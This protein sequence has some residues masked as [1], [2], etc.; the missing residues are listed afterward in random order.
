VPLQK[1]GRLEHLQSWIW[2]ADHSEFIDAI[3]L[4]ILRAM[5]GIGAAATI[6]ASLGILAQSFPPSH[7]RSV[8]FATFAA[9][10]PLGTIAG[11]S[12]GGLLIEKTR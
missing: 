10:Q 5:Q 9:G 7:L 1:V 12:L 8:A 3:T 2:Y 11:M 6:P 4:D